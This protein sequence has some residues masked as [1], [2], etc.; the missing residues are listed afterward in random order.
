MRSADPLPV[1]LCAAAP[2]VCAVPSPPVYK[3][4]GD[5]S[6]EAPCAVGRPYASSV[7]AAAARAAR[8]P[9]RTANLDWVDR[10]AP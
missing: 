2:L 8:I 7:Q 5:S 9:N 4:R 10:S 6:A 3:I 1:P